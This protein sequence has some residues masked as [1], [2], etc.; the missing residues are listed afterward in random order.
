MNRLSAN[1]DTHMTQAVP[2]DK[3]EEEALAGRLLDLAS[4]VVAGETTVKIELGIGDEELEAMYAVAYNQYVNKKYEEARAAFALL[5]L[6]D[7]LCHKYLLGQASCLQMTKEHEL[8][9]VTYLM[10]AAADPTAPAPYLHMAECLL[11]LK[12]H[13]GA[14]TALEKVLKLSG[15]APAWAGHRRRAEAMLENL[16]VREPGPM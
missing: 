16:A 1:E 14:K 7:P 2:H 6:F 5:L 12:D 10:A 9:C 13:E 4:R 15:D 3:T 11:M 8:A